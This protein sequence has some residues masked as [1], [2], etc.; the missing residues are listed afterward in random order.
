MPGYQHK[1]VLQATRELPSFFWDG[2]TD[3]TCIKDSMHHL[4]NHGYTHH[5]QRLMVLGNLAQLIGV[6]PYKFHEWHMAMYLDAIDWVSLPNTLGMSQYGDGG[7]VGT[8]PYCSTGNYI[9]KMSNFCKNCPYD[10]KKRHGKNACPFTTL[11]WDFLDRNQDL[12]QY[13]NR[14]SFAYKN[15]E[16]IQD[17]PKEYQLI[18]Q[19]ALTI[20]ENW[21]PPETPDS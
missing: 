10:F 11:Y 8:K 20:M 14:L 13:N 12:L 17:D 2:N 19:Q 5:I 16:R 6:H 4:L 3:M 7:I 9:S 18:K 1:N 15:L 21:Y